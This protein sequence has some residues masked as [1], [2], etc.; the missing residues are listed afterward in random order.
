LNRKF[1][2]LTFSASGEITVS[3]HGCNTS[4]AVRLLDSETSLAPAEVFSLRERDDGTGLAKRLAER[5]QVLPKRRK[6]VSQSVLIAL[7]NKGLL[8]E[9]TEI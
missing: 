2:Y 7:F 4:H 1:D 6:T 5:M 8:K 9:K 3:L